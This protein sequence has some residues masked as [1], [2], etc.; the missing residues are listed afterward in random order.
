MPMIAG[1]L[2]AP[3]NPVVGLL[4]PPR[5]AGLLAAPRP[6]TTAKASVPPALPTLILL[7]P[8]A[9][10]NPKPMPKSALFLLPPPQPPVAL[11]PAPRPSKQKCSPNPYTNPYPDTPLSLWERRQLPDGNPD[12]KRQ[13]T[14]TDR[15]SRAMNLSEAVDRYQS[16]RAKKLSA[17]LKASK[18]RCES[19]D[20]IRARMDKELQD[21]LEPFAARAAALAQRAH[22]PFSFDKEIVIS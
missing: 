16:R 11:L 5:V 20:D 7:P 10:R 18:P 8:P 22:K 17:M 1:L 2:P 15:P 9:V 13:R 6:R 21:V 19:A 14:R 12:K 3:I 4:P